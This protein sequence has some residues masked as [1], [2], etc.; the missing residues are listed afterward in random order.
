MLSGVLVG[1]LT[2]I[3]VLVVPALLLLFMYLI[4]KRVEHIE[5]IVLEIKDD[6]MHVLPHRIALIE[7]ILRDYKAE[8]DKDNVKPKLPQKRV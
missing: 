7:D 2:K 4:L 3:M 5:Q 8:M 6:A 1:I